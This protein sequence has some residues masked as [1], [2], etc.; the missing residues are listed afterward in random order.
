M[1]THYRWETLLERRRT[2]WDDHGR[3]SSYVMYKRS[4]G[5]PES[6]AAQAAVAEQL[7]RLLEPGPDSTLLDVGCGSGALTQ[8][9]LSHFR[10]VTATDLAPAMLRHAQDLLPGVSCHLAPAH[11]LPFA[12]GSFSRVLCYGVFL[13]FPDFDYARQAFLE[14]MRVLEPCGIAVMGDVPDVTKKRLSHEWR[15][16]WQQSPVKAAVRSLRDV[17]SDLVK[18][19]R[20]R[21]FYSMAFFENLATEYGCGCEVVQQPA[22]VER[23]AWRVNVV[24][25][26]SQ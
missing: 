22:Q 7:L 11:E 23:S 1:G 9:L 13:L 6:P 25:R 16:R 14:M 2:E 8:H 17:A 19:P 21:G 18:G 3:D 24:M 10:Q 26:K 5:S 4:D 12:D 20:P 15:S